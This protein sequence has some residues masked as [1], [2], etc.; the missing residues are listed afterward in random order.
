MITDDLPTA[1]RVVVNLCLLA[2]ALLSYP[3]PFYAAAEILQT[4]VLKL[5]ASADGAERRTLLLRGSLLL[6]TLVMALY[7]PHFSLLMGLTGSVTG[8][9]M[10]LLLPALFHLQLK[11][12]ELDVSRRAADLL[13]FLL[14]CF[15][16]VS[17]VVCSIKGMVTAF[18]DK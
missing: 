13:I 12:T 8:A 2:K 18:E 15:C 5:D 17:G 7:V 14:G 11:W 6:L 3:L 9:A 4:A 1:L 10:T 16:S